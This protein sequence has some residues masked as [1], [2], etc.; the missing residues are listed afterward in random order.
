[1]PEVDETGMFSLG[2]RVGDALRRG[3][4]I[5][6]R[7]GGDGAPR[8]GSVSLVAMLSL[9]RGSE[10]FRDTGLAGDV[11]VTPLP[12]LLVDE[13]ATG[14]RRCALMVM[15]GLAAIREGDGDLDL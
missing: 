10:R 4:L 13:G 14:R 11:V 6:P 9:K 8:T 15:G 2:T 1:M 7:P 5:L 12:L 3:K